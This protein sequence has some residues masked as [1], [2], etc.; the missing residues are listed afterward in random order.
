MGD[1]LRTHMKLNHPSHIT[2]DDATAR[3]SMISQ[4]G[5]TLDKANEGARFTL[6][7]RQPSDGYISVS[8]EVESNDHTIYADGTITIAY[9]D[10]GM[11][12]EAID[13][14][15][16]FELPHQINDRLMALGYHTKDITA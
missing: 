15:G 1:A 6:E 5:H 12:G 14:D 3:V 11:M 10:D 13:F 7:F 8:W 9:K 2:W 4:G 16:A